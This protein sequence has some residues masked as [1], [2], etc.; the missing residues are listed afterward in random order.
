MT[1]ATGAVGAAVVERFQRDEHEVRALVRGA[2]R[3]AGVETLRGDLTERPAVTAAVRGVDLAVHCA[4][5]RSADLAECQRVNVDGTRCLVE[6]LAVERARLVHISTVSVY[7]D[8]AGPS[9][10]EDSALATTPE[11]AYGFT[12]AQAER[13]IRTSNLDAVVLRPALILSMHPRSRWGPLAVA[14]A[15]LEPGCLVPYPELP[16]VHVDNLVEAIVLAARAPEA[17]GRAY[18]VV[19][20][21]A[22][23]RAYLDAVYGAAGRAPPP[24]PPGAPRLRFAADRIRREL[25]WAPRDR[26]RDFLAELRPAF[27]T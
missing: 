7:A 17:R 20:G 10:D 6:A 23:T 3:P 14:R 27:P 2:E 19:E 1:G 12:K 25:A 26:W 18:N 16:Y 11:D 8:A 15:R 24:I 22:D 9:Y 4:A 21:V 5:S 13:V